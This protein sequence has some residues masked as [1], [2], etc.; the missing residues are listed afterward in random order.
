MSTWPS[1]TVTSISR[2]NFEC[3][4]EGCTKLSQFQ[5]TIVT[6]K[7]FPDAQEVKT[8]CLQHAPESAMQMWRSACDA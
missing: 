2:L 6:N 3:D 7:P 4:H 5:V 8:Y 1:G